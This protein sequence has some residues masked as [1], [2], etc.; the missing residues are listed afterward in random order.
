MVK[1]EKNKMGDTCPQ[2][3]SSG[4]GSGSVRRQEADVNKGHFEEQRGWK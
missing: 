1:R 4:G 2:T 3:R